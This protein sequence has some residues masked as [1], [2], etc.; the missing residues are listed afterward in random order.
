MPS[1]TSQSYSPCRWNMRGMYQR[2][3]RPRR[4]RLQMQSGGQP[5]SLPGGL[6]SLLSRLR[7]MV[8]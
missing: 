4:V 2:K 8:W 6:C 1:E 5:H 7:A 3:A